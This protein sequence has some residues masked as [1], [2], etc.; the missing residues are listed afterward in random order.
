MAG[1][2]GLLWSQASRPSLLG[3]TAG[4][5]GGPKELWTENRSS[6]GLSFSFWLPQRAGPLGDRRGAFPEGRKAQRGQ[7]PWMGTPACS[8]DSVPPA[9]CLE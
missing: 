6:A 7:S 4:A 3:P 9:S 2:A 5:P 1:P 8:A